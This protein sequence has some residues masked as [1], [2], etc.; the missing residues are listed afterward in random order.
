MNFR[1]A[2]LITLVIGVLALGYAYYTQ[3][4]LLYRPCEICQFERWP[5]RIVI[6]LGFFALLLGRDIARVFVA[7][8]GLA[9]L[10]NVGISFMH[11]GV[12]LNWWASPF[13]EC[14]DILMP[15]APLPATPGISCAREVFPVSWLPVS[16][17]Q[18]DLIGSILF[19]V[20]LFFMASRS[21][22]R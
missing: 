10:A 16:M 3:Y 22:K 12:E 14:N 4:D 20:F 6:V 1:L 2:G 5:Y 17:T 13:P 15:G 11:V 8:A 9:M 19:T 18:L 7:L 21:E